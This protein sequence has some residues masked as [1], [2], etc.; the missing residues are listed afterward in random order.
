MPAV[1][2]EAAWCSA[3]IEAGI[4]PE[5]VGRQEERCPDVT[6]VNGGL[7]WDNEDGTEA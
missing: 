2:E 5:V 3:G 4:T 6:R 1:G 7:W